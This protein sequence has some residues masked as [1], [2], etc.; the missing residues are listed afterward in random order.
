MMSDRLVAKTIAAESADD[1]TSPDGVG[2]RDQRVL[3]P[4]PLIYLGGLAIGFGLQAL[5]PSTPLPGAVS[6]TVGGVGLVTGGALVRSFFRA[7]ARART[8]VS[9]YGA[10]TRL[11]TTGP[12]GLTRNPG[13]LGMALAY[14]GVAVM[15]QTLWALVPLVVV[16]VLVDRGVIAREERYLERTFGDEYRGYKRRVGRWV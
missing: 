8:P 7:F 14:I 9:P 2:E 5:L 16:L 13:Y 3:A 12:Y 6:W 15:S 1:G 11:V 10:P 4:P